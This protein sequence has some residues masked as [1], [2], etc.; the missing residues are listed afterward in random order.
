MTVTTRQYL[1]RAALTREMVDRFLDPGAHNKTRFDTVLGYLP[2][3]ESTE[4]RPWGQPL[5]KPA[6]AALNL[7]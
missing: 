5:K 2:K 1:S 7:G 4:G 3:P 6:G